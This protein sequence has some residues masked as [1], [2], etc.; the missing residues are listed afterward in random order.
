MI[1][2]IFSDWRTGTIYVGD[3]PA[4]DILFREDS[5]AQL[6]FNIGQA[7]VVT[8]IAGMKRSPSDLSSFS[9]RVNSPDPVDVSRQLALY[10]SNSDLHRP[11]TYNKSFASSRNQSSSSLSGR[12]DSRPHSAVSDRESPLPPVGQS[13]FNSDY[14]ETPTTPNQTN[15]RRN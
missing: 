4:E 14:M 13:L 5:G 12:Q 7:P 11:P 15:S 10:P 6:K 2:W 9:L 8:T 3:K 1:L